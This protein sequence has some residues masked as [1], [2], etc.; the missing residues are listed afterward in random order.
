MFHSTG[1]E[2]QSSPPARELRPPPRLRPVRRLSA[3]PGR[4][5]RAPLVAGQRASCERPIPCVTR[6]PGSWTKTSRQREAH[7]RGAAVGTARP[8]ESERV[9]ARNSDGH[10]EIARDERV[11]GTTRAPES[12]RVATRNSDGHDEIAGE[13]GSGQS[14]PRTCPGGQDS[15]VRVCEH[16]VAG[17]L[18]RA[19]L[20]WASR[21]RPTGGGRDAGGAEAEARAQADL[22][23]TRDL[24]NETCPPRHTDRVRAWP[25]STCF[26]GAPAAREGPVTAAPRPPHPDLRPRA[27]RSREP[28]PGAPSLLRAPESASLLR[29]PEHASLPRAR[30]PRACRSGV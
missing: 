18:R 21:G 27:P 22:T 4:P 10:D 26:G 17:A 8:P 29:A 12:E 25:P 5:R 7:R 19:G 28:P 13:R 2:C 23:G 6:H 11:A 15:I 14:A 30:E 3:A 20:A 24:S 16:E 1:L 9:A